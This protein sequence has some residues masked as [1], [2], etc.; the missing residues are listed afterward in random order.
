MK[1]LVAFNVLQNQSSFQLGRFLQGQEL[2]V[3][4]RMNEEDVGDY[5]LLKNNFLKKFRLTEGGY[6]KRFKHSKIE[7][8][9]TPEQFIDRLRRYL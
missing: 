7:N 9:D 8:G 5:D 3:Y 4:Q 1:E 2:D 6:R